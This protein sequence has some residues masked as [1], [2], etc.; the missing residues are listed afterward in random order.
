MIAMQYSIV[1]PAD[2]D[3]AVID[4]RVRDKGPLLD[5]FPHLRFKAYLVARK[6]GGDVI[7]TENLYAPFYLWDHPE[8]LNQFL[9][10]PGFAAVARDFGWPRVAS[11]MVWESLFSGDLP[12]ARFASRRV[13]PIAPY[14]DL[15][16]RRADARQGAESAL[17][18]GAIA[19][20]TAFDP[21]N[22]TQ[23][24]FRLWPSLP[25]AGAEDEQLYAV[26]HVSEGRTA[27]T[28]ASRGRGG[29]C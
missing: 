26:R 29:A 23:I 3:M 8:G 12:E 10:G 17:G 21:A 25:P 11:W 15:A 7:S 2:Y 28:T 9:G 16:A 6:D 5:G 1:L 22:W 14:S 27:D 4:R 18:D 13:E 24:H 20:V 19:A